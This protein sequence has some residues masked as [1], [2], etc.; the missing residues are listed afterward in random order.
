M[1]SYNK[2]HQNLLRDKVEEKKSKKTKLKTSDM[3]LKK[4][5]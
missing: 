1:I 2:K 5:K 3:I 4:V